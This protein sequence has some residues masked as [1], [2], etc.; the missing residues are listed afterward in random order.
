MKRKVGIMG[1]SFDPIHT[2]HLFVANEAL[3]IYKLDEIIFV[4]TGDPP[5]K[6]KLRADSFHRLFMV[7]MAVLSNEKFRVSDLEIEC[8]DKSYS[9]NTLREF[10]KLYENTEFYFI[11]GTDAV[12]DLPNWHKP[13]EVLKLCRFVAA[14]R[15][16]ISIEKVNEKIDE[17][18]KNFGGNIELLQVPMLQISSTE[19]RERIS[20]GVSVK[21]LLPECVEQYIIKNEL[22]HRC[23]DTPLL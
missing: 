12:I 13:E 5:H 16:G 18:R 3:N 14:S 21:Y 22:Y 6:A 11:T 4:P 17:I 19:I 23:G 8:K 1:G 7:N 9:L 10:H 2:G 20:M 15:P